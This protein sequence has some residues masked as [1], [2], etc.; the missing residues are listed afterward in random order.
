[1]DGTTSPHRH[2]GETSDGDLSD[3]VD[4]DGEDKVKGE[5]EGNC[6]PAT[7][8]S[9]IA[10][11][12]SDADGDPMLA[13]SLFPSRR[14]PGGRD[15]PFSSEEP[16]PETEG[17]ILSDAVRRAARQVEESPVKAEEDSDVESEDLNADAFDSDAEGAMDS[18]SISGDV[19]D[20]GEATQLSHGAIQRNGFAGNVPGRRKKN[21]YVF[22][23]HDEEE[24]EG[25]DEDDGFFVDDAEL[26]YVSRRD[27][28]DDESE[29]ESTDKEVRRERREAQRQAKQ[30]ARLAQPK[31]K[32]ESSSDFSDESSSEVSDSEDEDAEDEPEDSAP[33]SDAPAGVKDE[34]QIPTLTSD[35]VRQEMRDRAA[36]A[37]INR[38]SAPAQSAPRRAGMSPPTKQQREMERLFAERSNLAI[39]A[40]QQRH[41]IQA[42]P[43]ATASSSRLEI[44]APVARKASSSKKAAVQA[45]PRRKK[46]I[47]ETDSEAD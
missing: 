13:E 19:N 29:A 22:D 25:E 23:S 44:E 27:P 34:E 1:M 37:A 33:T 43:S 24:D 21:R 36:S 20:E 38:M 10:D 16:E 17:D 45:A 9:R 40:Y 2:A 8:T 42:A 4:D 18:S 26:E 28:D 15:H 14:R 7:G 11:E 47:Q 32:A 31:S 46:V 6:I 41:G 5:S 30:A 35:A 3:L 39:A 12:T